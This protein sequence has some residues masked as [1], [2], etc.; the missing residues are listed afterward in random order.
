M[1][2]KLILFCSLLLA[3]ASCNSSQNDEPVVTY[4]TLVTYVSSDTEQQISTFNYQAIDDSPLI[5]LTANWLP[6]AD[7][8]TPG[9]RVM[10]VY[11]AEKYGVSGPVSVIQVA[12]VIGW[13]PAVTQ[14][15]ISGNISILP[16]TVWRSG[17]Y[18]NANI[19][20]TLTKES[21]TAKF[22]LLESTKNDPEPVFYLTIT[23]T[24]YREIEAIRRVATVSFNISE[25]WNLPTCTGI[26][27]IYL[28][29]AT[30]N[31]EEI[32]LKKD[33]K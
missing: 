18:F 2:K 11:K 33:K 28:S 3:L 22:A 26:K 7:K 6:A 27:V 5:T 21:A 23:Q 12:P 13:T 25:V 31:E 30:G 16:I 4:T 19:E 9:E 29:S 24:N 1:M 32:L 15:P 8:Y 10:L 17:P 14:E 20:A